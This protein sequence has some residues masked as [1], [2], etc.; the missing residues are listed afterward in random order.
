MYTN[1]GTTP[2]GVN[3]LYVCTACRER[4]VWR[5]RCSFVTTQMVDRNERLDLPAD[6]RFYTCAESE[7]LYHHCC[8]DSA[9][10]GAC[11][12]HFH[13]ELLRPRAVVESRREEDMR[14][15]RTKNRRDEPVLR[16]KP[17]GKCGRRRDNTEDGTVSRI[18]PRE[19]K[20]C[21]RNS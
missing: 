20:S 12:F 7:K 5:N 1:P 17:G 21:K 6:S 4:G 3:S 11:K 10:T 15:D 13:S 8:I 18:Y 16:D 14:G 2:A 9:D 19:G